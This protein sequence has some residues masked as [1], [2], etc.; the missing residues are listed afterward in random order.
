MIRSYLLVAAGEMK[1]K[2]ERPLG[3]WNRGQENF[4]VE[5]GLSYLPCC[6]D[7]MPNKNNFRKSLFGLAIQGYSFTIA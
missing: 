3:D 2:Q 1:E 5:G 6:W 4:G 7:K